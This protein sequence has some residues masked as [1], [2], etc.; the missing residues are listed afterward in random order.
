MQISNFSEENVI[1][2][3]MHHLLVRKDVDEGV[4]KEP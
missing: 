4:V 3:R 1:W 2:R